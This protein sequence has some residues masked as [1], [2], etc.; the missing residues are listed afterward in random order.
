MDQ[1]K[2]KSQLFKANLYLIQFPV[3]LQLRNVGEES[4]R[5]LRESFLFLPNYLP[6]MEVASTAMG[7]A[8]YLATQPILISSDLS[9]R[10][11]QRFGPRLQ[12]H[13]D[14]L[15]HVQWPVTMLWLCW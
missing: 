10:A 11:D 7:R 4:A 13:Q 15:R 1:S 14:I 12:L 8:I 2:Q 3:N 5:K 9:W 6:Q